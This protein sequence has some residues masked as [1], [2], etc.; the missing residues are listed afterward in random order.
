M[1]IIKEYSDCYL[2]SDLQEMMLDSETIDFVVNDIESRLSS[3]LKRWE[4]LE[5]RNTLLYIG[6]EEG[7]FYK[8]K[9][10]T[11]ISS[12]VVVA[13]R[14]SIIED[15]A[16]TDEAAQQYGFDK[17]PLSDKDIPK[18]TSNAIKYF[19]KC[20]LGDFDTKSIN[21]YENDLFY[22]LPKKYPVAWNALSHLSRGSKEMS[23]EP[24]KEKEIRV[25]ELKRNNKSY[26]LHRNS[27]QSLV[28][29]GM[30]PTIDNQSID[31]FREVKNDLDNVFFTDSFKGITRNID[32]LLH[33]IEF[34]LRSNIPVVT[35][36]C[37]ISNGYV[38]NRKEKWQ[39]PFHYT[40]DVQKKAKMKHNDCS[41]SHKKVLMLQRNHS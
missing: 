37:Y 21:T 28:Q 23:F 16:S 4:D 18:L 13:V 2:R 35:F 8:P 9:V 5:F 27:K 24:K 19:S 31:Y 29:S 22:D 17:P 7:L 20:N 33:I 12:L 38:A 25:R 3:I 1:N 11:D 14:N 39:K 30:D 40:I 41:E 34:F 36:N 26:N 15:L 6:K 32:K 10:D